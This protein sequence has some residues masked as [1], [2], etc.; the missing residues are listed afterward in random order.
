VQKNKTF[1][2]VDWQGTRLNTGA[3]RTSTVPTSAQKRGVFTQ[4]IF[5]PLSTRQTASGYVRDPFPANT[6]P[7]SAIDPATQAVVDRYP[8]P[9][10][11][12]GAA[13]ATANNYRRVGTDTTGQDQFDLRLDRYV[14]SRH[15]FFGRYSYLRDDSTPATPLPDGSGTFTATYIGQTLTRADSV[16]AEH[17][18]NLTPASV[19]Q[20][21]FGF[22]RRG[23]DRSSL[24]TGQSASQTSRIPNIPLT[25]F[26]DV[27]PTYDVVGMQQLGPP[28]NGNAEFTTSVT[29]IIDNYTWVRGKHSLKAGTD[30][31]FERL[32]VLQPPSPTGNFQFSNIFTAGLSAAGTPTANT[33]NSFASFLTGAVTRF[34]IDAQEEVLKPRASIAEFFLQDDWRATRSLSVNLG[35]RYTLNFPSTVADDR[36]A[37]FNLGTQKLEY[38]GKDG[39]PRAARDLEKANFGP[40]VGLAWRVKDDFVVRSGYSLTWIEQAGITTPFTTPL[41]PFIQTLGQATLDNINPAFSFARTDGDAAARGSGRGSWPGRVRRAAQQ[42][43]RV[44]AAVELE[45]AKNLTVRTGAWRPVIWGRS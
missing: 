12:S 45:P 2:F 19:N 11:F 24:A 35:V 8:A 26:S 1:F 21:R 44:C 10:V 32:D 36:G 9:N 34:S 14:G 17:S 37:V 38:F 5:D 27:L 15:K 13:E 42:R 16:V 31:R 39:F 7:A 33:G 29:Q 6:I 23:F 4:P 40:R 25:S 30:I 20:L 28:A 22:T 41:F 18:W 43:Q 3:V